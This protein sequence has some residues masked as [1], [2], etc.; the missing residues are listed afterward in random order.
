MLEKTMAAAQIV[1]VDGE[2]KLQELHG[3]TPLWAIVQNTIP[4]YEELQLKYGVPLIRCGLPSRGQMM[5]EYGIDL[6]LTKPIMANELL[7]VYRNMGAPQNVVMVD[8]DRGFCHLI[9]EILSESNPAICFKSAYSVAQGVALINDSSPDLLI[10]DLILGDGDGRKMLK[11]V[12]RE[13]ITGGSV[14]L[15]TATDTTGSATDAGCESITIQRAPG[16]SIAEAANIFAAILDA[17]DRV[18]TAEY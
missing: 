6:C 18:A 2:R 9:G 15:L 7:S 3:A 12:Q 17:C 14:L 1:Q 11:Q 4:G 16:F 8:D 13:R 10:I 5:R